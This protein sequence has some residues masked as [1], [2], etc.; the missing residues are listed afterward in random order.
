MEDQLTALSERW[1]H[2]CSWTEKRGKILQK[3][4][5]QVPNFLKKQRSLEEWLQ[6]QEKKLKEVESNPNDTSEDS[7]MERYEKLQVATFRSNLE[8]FLP[9][10]L[11]DLDFSF[12]Y[13]LIEPPS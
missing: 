8:S 2:I 1:A 10:K 13:L 7:L 5:G 6:Q 11:G 12:G 9:Q 3:L 4:R